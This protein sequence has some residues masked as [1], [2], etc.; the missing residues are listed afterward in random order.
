MI[1]VYITT[2]IV[3]LVYSTKKLS[4]PNMNSDVRK[5][6]FTRHAA[7]ISLNIICNAYFM[8]TIVVWWSKK[9]RDSYNEIDVW[10]TRMMKIL[11]TSQGLLLP[12]LRLNEPLFL[13]I[14]KKKF[15]KFIAWLTCKTECSQAI[16][17]VNEQKYD[18]AFSKRIQRFTMSRNLN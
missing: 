13:E 17:T 4:G 14:S 11:F 1:V 8:A 6:V 15:R 12:F 10:W 9:W 3:S 2:F 5:L 7:T 18:K 16:E